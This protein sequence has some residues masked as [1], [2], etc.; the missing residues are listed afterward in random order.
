[1]SI[2]R[3][4]VVDIIVSC[5][6]DANEELGVRELENPTEDT[7]I[8]GSKG[9]FDSLALVRLVVAVEQEISSEFGKTIMLADERAMSQKRSPFRKVKNLADYANALLEE[10]QDE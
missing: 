1:M 7:L 4:K 10:L 9:F 6:R 3:D 5:I 2:E 8:Y